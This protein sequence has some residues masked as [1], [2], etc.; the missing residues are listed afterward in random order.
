[1]YPTL[2]AIAKDLLAIP[3]STVASESAFST[4]GR[5]L[6]PHRSRLN[7]TTL[8]A[9]MCAISWLWSAENAGNL[10]SS[11]KEEY[12]T[13]LNE[14]ESDDEAR[15]I[16]F[17]RINVR[18]NMLAAV[19]NMRIVTGETCLSILIDSRPSDKFSPRRETLAQAINSR[20]GDKFS[21]KREGTSSVFKKGYGVK[22]FIHLFAKNDPKRKKIIL[23]SSSNFLSISRRTKSTANK[24]H[25]TPK[26]HKSGTSGQTALSFNR[27]KFT[28][29]ERDERYTTL[30]QWA[31]VPERRVDLQRN[32]YPNL[33]TRL[34][35]LKWGTIASPHDKFDHDVV[36][37]FY[38][39]AY[40][41]EEGE[42]L[43]EQKSCTLLQWA[44]VPERKVDLQRNE[45]PN[46]LTRL[47][48]LKWGTIASPH[49]KFDHDVVQEF[50][51]NAYPPAE[52]EGL[53][54][55]KSWVR[56]KVIRYDRDYLNMMLNNP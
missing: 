56:G 3:I 52:G 18:G 9:L 37:E 22:P 46:L 25:P 35:A 20:P 48:A 2:Q 31:F 39:N 44:F 12:A 29:L 34:D 13:V 4:S 32:E 23:S 54:E 28:S 14:I 55:Q 8:D 30:I 41:P 43:F 5:I 6:S 36:R 40:P 16:W 7:W 50:Y 33:L 51:A 26:K 45:Y 38:A 10:N 15:Y 19:H 11:L 21:L 49:D 17:A 24:I 53:F 42:G 27:K 1:M 47:D